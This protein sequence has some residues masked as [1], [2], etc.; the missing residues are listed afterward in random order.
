[1]SNS[2]LEH[3]RERVEDARKRLLDAQQAIQ[4]LQ[5]KLA[6][7]NAEYNAWHTVFQLEQ[8]RVA[9][10]AEN[11]DQ[12]V[13]EL[14]GPEYIIETVPL[15][16]EDAG[17]QV[18]RTDLVRD[19]IRAHPGVTTAD[20]WSALQGSIGN[21]AYLYSITKRLRDRKEIVMRRGKFYLNARPTGIAQEGDAT[22]V[23]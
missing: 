17:E 6:A 12:L 16:A 22:V 3:L 10:A 11:H 20:L 4:F 7:A 23:Q 1:M 9:A 14:E 8:Q 2:V 13:I 15:P 19:Q 18:N 5:Q 21:R